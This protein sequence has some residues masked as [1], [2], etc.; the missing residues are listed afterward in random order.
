METNKPIRIFIVEDSEIYARS[1]KKKL[2]SEG[3]EVQHFSTG[4]Q[5]IS[6]W[7]DDPD[8]ILLDYNIESELGVAMNGEKILRFIR[9]ISRNLPV[10]TLT[11]TND[12]IG[13]ATNM[14]KLGA[15]DFIVKRKDQE[16]FPDLLKTIR[17]VL[18]ARI[19]REEMSK[20]KIRVKKY[21]QH[22]VIFI[23]SIALAAM[24]L[25]WLLS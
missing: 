15:V 4:E 7:E 21:Q 6:S 2:E 22:L 24:T 20:N 14:L 1:L 17:Q 13:M 10:I 23:L 3:F 8:I 9:R 11:A 16:A 19:L 18:E 12:D 25:L 5:M